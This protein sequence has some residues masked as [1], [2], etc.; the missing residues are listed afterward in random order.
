MIHHVVDS[1]VILFTLRF[2]HDTTY[3]LN[4]VGFGCGENNCIECWNIQTLVRLTECG[5]DDLFFTLFREVLLFHTSHVE[6]GCCFK[7]IV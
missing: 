3:T 2:S 7:L 6:T 5:E 4:N 1:G